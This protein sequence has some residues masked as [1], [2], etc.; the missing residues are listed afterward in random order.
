MINESLALA[1]FLS[2]CVV[3]WS[4]RWAWECV[5]FPSRRDRIYSEGFEDG[6]KFAREHPSH[7]RFPGVR[8]PSRK[9]TEST[10]DTDTEMG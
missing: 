9:I 8:L 6:E 5:G 7:D 4:I 1:G 10:T 2:G 3:G